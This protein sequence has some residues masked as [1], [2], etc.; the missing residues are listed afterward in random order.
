MPNTF[1]GKTIEKLVDTTNKWVLHRATKVVTNTKDY[2]QNSRILPDYL[3][4]LEY[5]YPILGHQQAV[6]NI[7]NKHK[8]R[9][10]WIGRMASEKGLEFLIE[11]VELI[12]KEKP[13]WN[14]ELVLAGPVW[15]SGEQKYKTNI[16][17]LIRNKNNIK[18]IGELQDKQLEEFYASLDILVISSINATETLGMVQLEAMRIGVRVVATNLPGVREPIR[19]TGMGIVVEPKNAMALAEGIINLYLKIKGKRIKVTT[20][21]IFNPKT[22]LDKY[23]HLLLS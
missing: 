22:G 9:L 17:K 23:E 11:A 18:H 14:I 4:K 19:K 2:A 12:E 15:T 1:T 10:G 21:D 13:K 6:K 8:I 20:E 7:N 3:P 5:I 16:L